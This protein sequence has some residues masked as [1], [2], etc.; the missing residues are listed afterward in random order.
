MR[1]LFVY[2][3]LIS[4]I[5][6]FIL[7]SNTLAT[8]LISA[9]SFLEKSYENSK[10]YRKSSLSLPKPCVRRGW[11]LH[12]CSRQDPWDSWRSSRYLTVLFRLM[13]FDNLPVSARDSQYA[14]DSPTT[15]LWAVGAPSFRNPSK[16]CSR[17]WRW[18]TRVQAFPA[19]SRRGRCLR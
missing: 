9:I 19:T 18:R 16:R 1:D 14:S 13:G 4:A 6:I 17:A 3:G 5:L 10:S 7:P 11:F 8:I 12:P 15:C 2:S